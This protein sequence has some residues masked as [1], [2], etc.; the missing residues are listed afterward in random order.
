MPAL[1][2]TDLIDRCHAG[3]R[4][5]GFWDVTPHPGQQNALIASELFEALEAHR[6]GLRAD[7]SLYAESLERVE[8]MV[9][10]EHKEEAWARAFVAC[11][12]DTVEDELADA[13]IRL[14]DYVGGY[15]VPVSQLLAHYQH[16]SSREDAYHEDFEGVFGADVLQA[17]IAVVEIDKR[18]GEQA[19]TRLSR[20]FEEVERLAA[21]Y[22]VDLATHIDLKLRYNATRPAKHGKAY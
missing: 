10:A 2:T 18:T 16:W 12:K 7:A 9:P 13:Y 6:K 14:C 17:V 19:M 20:A 1:L 8:L 4:A 21:C 15:K 11:Y 22:K 3:S 5:K